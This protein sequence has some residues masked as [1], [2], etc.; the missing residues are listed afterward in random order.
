MAAGVH[1]RAKEMLHDIGY[2]TYA[3]FPVLKKPAN[4]HRTIS[5]NPKEFHRAYGRMLTQEKSDALHELW[6]VPWCRPPLFEDA[7]AHTFPT[8]AA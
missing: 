5:L 8:V 1:Y 2:T 3:R 7:G 4:L 6:T